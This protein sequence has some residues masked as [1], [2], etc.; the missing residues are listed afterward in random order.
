MSMIIDGTSG[1]TFPDGTLQAG[2]ASLVTLGTITFSGTGTGTQHSLSG[3]TL[4]FYKMLFIQFNGVG[5]GGNSAGSISFA[6]TTGDQS[7]NNK[8][9][10]GTAGTQNILYGGFY[11]DL[12][13]GVTGNLKNGGLSILTSGTVASVPI[14]LGTS[15]SGG[16]GSDGP[17]GLSTS[18]TTLYVYMSS[19][20]SLTRI[21]TLTVYGVR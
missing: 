10:M 8:I 17:T 7:T 6:N 20:N 3:L 18:S 2:Q 16:S 4:T 13:S 11:I 5:L 21:G 9:T 1:A 19:T 14:A 15:L 12:L